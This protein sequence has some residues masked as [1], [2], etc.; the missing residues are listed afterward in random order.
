MIV[1]VCLV[2]VLGIYSLFKGMFDIMMCAPYLPDRID[3]RKSRLIRGVIMFL[4]PV[5]VILLILY[6]LMT[7]GS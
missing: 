4:V 7:F 5:A 2:G 1:L 6:D 3:E